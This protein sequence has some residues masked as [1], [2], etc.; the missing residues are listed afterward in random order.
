LTVR[1]AAG[2]SAAIVARHHQTL[3]GL[4]FQRRARLDEPSQI[5]VPSVKATAFTAATNVDIF[6]KW[7][8]PA[9]LLCAMQG[10][11]VC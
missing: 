3:P 9:P 2:P 11:H 7:A 4:R 1:T 8:L 5:D 10:A 6:I